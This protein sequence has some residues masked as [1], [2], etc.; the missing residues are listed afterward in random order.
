LIRF[1]HAYFPGRTLL[2]GISEGCLVA[3]AFLTATIVRLGTND[4]S[5]VLSYEQGFVKIDES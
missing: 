4:A 3:L 1:L 2:L 5:L